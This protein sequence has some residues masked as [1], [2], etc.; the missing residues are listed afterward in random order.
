MAVST[1][2]AIHGFSLKLGSG[3]FFKLLEGENF[4]RVNTR[5]YSFSTK[6]QGKKQQS[7]KIMRRD[8][9]FHIIERK[10]K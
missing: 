5:N 2:P 10:G 8:E 7:N 3:V 1:D 4:K 6:I 9:D